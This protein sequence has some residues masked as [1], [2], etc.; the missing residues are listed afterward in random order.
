MKEL[1]V[2]TTVT[3]APPTVAP[4]TSLTVPTNVAP[5]P[6][7]ATAAAVATIRVTIPRSAGRDSDAKPGNRAILCSVTIVPRSALFQRSEAG[8]I[9]QAALESYGPTYWDSPGRRRRRGRPE[10]CPAEQ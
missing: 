2:L 8:S 6:V 1:A 7:W 9:Y 4:V 3:L 5:P 10:T